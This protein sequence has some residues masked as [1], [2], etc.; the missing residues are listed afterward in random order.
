MS[1]PSYMTHAARVWW[2]AMTARETLALSGADH[3]P[4]IIRGDIT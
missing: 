2:P 4:S 1:W 3:E